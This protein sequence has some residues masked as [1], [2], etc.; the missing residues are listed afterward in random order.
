[1][2]KKILDQ[3]FLSIEESDLI[4]F[5]VSARDGL[6]H[7]DWS[8]AKKIRTYK[9]SILVVVNKVDGLNINSIKSEF[10]ALGFSNVHAISATNGIGITALIQKYF[11]SLLKNISYS[12][13]NKL[14]NVS[15][16]EQEKNKV[17]W[18]LNNNFVKIAVVGKPNVGKST[19]INS[20][21][22]ENKMIV[23]DQPG[24]TRDSI[25]NIVIHKNNNYIFIDTAGVRKKNKITN[26]TEKFSVRKTLESIKLANIVILVLDVTDIISSQDIT[27]FN[28]IVENGC[29]IMIVFNKC[30]K[31]L[32]HDKRKILKSEKLKYMNVGVIHFISAV[33]K[34]GVNKIFTFIDKIFEHSVK[35]L[36]TSKLTEIMK[37]AVNM[38]QPPIIKNIR[39]KLKYAHLGKKNPLTI[40][41]HGNKLNYLS[42]TYKKYLSNYF[43]KALNIIGNPIHF[44]FK[45]SNN[46]FLK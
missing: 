34:L 36:S 10:Y 19:L 38:H 28:R 16:L 40:I 20:I 21:L 27:L 41:I 1:M 30:D 32:K 14:L 26:Y 46:P 25:W 42:D 31:L 3:V 7:E 29:G 9:K 8:I 17:R 5:L 33:N 44:Y 37:L 22:N 39:I 15:L 12:N 2:N 45:N 23:D 18:H 24:T 11:I 35:T 6:V 43:I 4:C 13:K